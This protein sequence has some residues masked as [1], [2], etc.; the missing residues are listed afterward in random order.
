MMNIFKFFSII[1][2]CLYSSISMAQEWEPKWVD[3]DKNGFNTREEFL[4]LMSLVEPEI[5][6]ETNKVT[7][8]KW[9][10]MLTGEEINE[11]EEVEVGHFFTYKNLKE[12][13]VN[14][15]PGNLRFLYN[16]PINLLT[17]KKSVL[18]ERGDKGLGEWEPSGL[19]ACLYLEHWL[20]LKNDLPVNVPREEMNNYI[21]L[22]NKNNC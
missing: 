20:D 13:Y 7:D 1:I 21:K 14:P 17:A 5:D 6:L 9:I 3:T 12:Y 8:G 10:D 15:T 11:V 2:F 18:E 22:Y 16:S 19:A 4:A